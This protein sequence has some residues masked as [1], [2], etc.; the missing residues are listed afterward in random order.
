MIGL[1]CVVITSLLTAATIPLIELAVRDIQRAAPLGVEVSPFKTVGSVSNLTQDIAEELKINPKDLDSAIQLAE[2]KNKALREDKS[3]ALKRQQDA[4]E[5]LLWVS[6]AVVGIFG[7][8][9]WFTRGSVY[10]TSKA[11]T[12]LANDLRDRIFTQL[13][14]LPI[15]YFNKKRAG[16]IQ[17]VMTND[18]N[19]YL[20]AVMVVR[21]SIDGPIKIVTGLVAVVYISPLLA[22]VAALFVPVV[23][24]VVQI[25]AK[26][27]KSASARVQDDLAELQAF[28]QEA[29][30]G[31][32]VIKA[33]S[34]EERIRGAFLERIHKFF[35]SQM[36]A[37]KRVASLKPLIEFV[38]AMALATIIYICGWLAF[39]GQLDIAKVTAL[40]YALDVVNQGWRALGYVRNTFA[41]VEAATDRIYN[42]VLDVP[43]EVTDQESAQIL[44][45]IVGKIEFKDV[46]F[47]Y[48][49]GTVALE[50]VNFTLEPGTSLALVGP[51]GAGKST[52]ADLLLR[53]YDPTEGQILLDGHDIRDLKA[54][55]L[56]TQ[57][58]VVPQTTF[59]F[60][61]SIAENLKL[62]APDAT[63]ADLEEA[64]RLAHVEPFVDRLPSRFDAHLGEQGAGL[65]GG[66]RQRLAIARALVKKPSIL[67]LDEATSNLDAESEKAV[68]EALTEVMTSRTTLFIAHRLTTA[69]RADKILV[70]RRGT[71]LEE[72]SH[73]ELMDKNESYA[74]MYRAFSN[75]LLEEPQ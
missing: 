65:S 12:L 70:L 37:V 11:S 18:T 28:T 55:W 7:I 72:G 75:G 46:S 19:V 66:E 26:K 8:K 54:E 42:E 45:S 4:L 44:S 24:V 32:R 27:M 20:N 64:A 49:D 40:V 1:A 30:Q 69:A 50:K 13:Q 74:A 14:R 16:S 6:L 68:T 39:R 36:N 23:A 56:R 60:A 2:A 47:T 35:N 67:L 48:P 51:S 41:Q 10:Y 53:F 38:G 22:L 25:N 71:V 43:L 57:I 5:H 3:L 61:G 29:I 63:E 59:L 17:S 9:Y 21:D 52:I 62:G 33:F 15:A 58:G 34:A 31:T 73:R